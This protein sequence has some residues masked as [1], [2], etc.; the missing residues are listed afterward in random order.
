VVGVVA[1]SP[2]LPGGGERSY[3]EERPHAWRQAEPDAG[4]IEVEIDGVIV[5]VCALATESQRP[6]PH[7][8]ELT[9]CPRVAAREQRH[10]GRAPPARYKLGDHTLGTAVELWRHAFGKRSELGDPHSLPCLPKDGAHDPGHGTRYQVGHGQKRPLRAS[11]T[12]DD[13]L[14]QS[15]QRPQHSSSGSRAR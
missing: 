8:M 15:R 14:R 3:S 6:R 11:A 5:R 7:R 12:E 1:S 10:R 13:P 9:L 4:M 2:G